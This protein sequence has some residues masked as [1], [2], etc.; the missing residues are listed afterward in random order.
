MN[1]SI[2]H[3]FNEINIDNFFKEVKK[4]I[5]NEI[6]SKPKEYIIGVDKMDY[7][8]YLTSKYSIDELKI[9]FHSEEVQLLKE[10]EREKV[11][12]WYGQEKLKYT[13]YVFRIKYLYTGLAKILQLH[14][15]NNYR[16][17]IGG[18]GKISNIDVHDNYIILFFSIFKQDKAEFNRVKEG[19]IKKTFE[20]LDNTLWYVQNFNNSLFNYVEKEFDKI[21]LKY[22]QDSNFFKELNIGYTNKK[23]NTYEIPIIQKRVNAPS[24]KQIDKP[25]PQLEMTIYKQ[26]IHTIYNVYKGFERLP[27]NYRNKDEEALR[28]GLLPSLQTIFGSYSSS[29][30]TFNKEG[31]TD[32]CIK[33]SGGGN[34][35]VAECK[36]W[37]GEKLFLDAINQLFDR[38][39]TWRDTKTALIVF[40]KNDS[41]SEIVEKAKSAILGHEYYVRSNGS[42][43]ETSFSYEF[44]LPN[45][46]NRIIYLELM[47]FHFQ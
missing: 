6:M 22:E 4:T 29:G 21:R 41:F 45:D 8:N 24:I 46:K 37:K 25:S 27:N 18:S 9:D 28:D 33:E 11:N 34:V 17:T 2:Y 30:E 26:I 15:S 39:V 12:E 1:Y 14:P 10:I 36:I 40:V 3:P 38:Y 16:W 5:C 13:E 44:H 43:G 35:F 42:S 47:M 20:N 19:T 32:I 7:V 31:K 23:N